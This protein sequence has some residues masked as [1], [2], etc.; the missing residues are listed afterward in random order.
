[1]HEFA[2][3]HR[4]CCGPGSPCSHCPAKRR[5][6]VS[7]GCGNGACRA[8]TLH[9]SCDSSDHRVRQ[10]S[11]VAVCSTC[12]LRHRLVHPVA[13]ARSLGMASHSNRWGMY[14]LRLH[15]V[16]VAFGA[17]SRVRTASALGSHLT[18]RCSRRPPADSRL[19]RCGRRRGR[20]PRLNVAVSPTIPRSHHA[21]VPA[22]CTQAV[23]AMPRDGSCER[24]WH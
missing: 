15:C 12:R 13:R 8:C 6:V 23:R 22:R 17:L 4:L 10:R 20:R 1:M 3:C 7:R 9:G 16:G 14:Y 21:G 24:G 19:V 5:P 2:E 18:P 11:D